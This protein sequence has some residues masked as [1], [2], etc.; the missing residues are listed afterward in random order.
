M[1]YSSVRFLHIPVKNTAC[2]GSSRLTKGGLLSL[3]G[4]SPFV[5]PP[6]TGPSLSEE[7]KQKILDV[8]DE[9]GGNLNRS[10][11]ILGI[12][13]SSLRRRIAEWASRDAAGTP[14]ESVSSTRRFY[15]KISHPWSVTSFNPE[16]REV[17]IEIRT[18][19]SSNHL[20]FTVPS[21]KMPE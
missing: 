11:V 8:I 1:R 16:K 15:E 12:S 2:S 9:N 10:S 19:S 13:A 6:M 4:Y 20:A 3:M 5:S 7:K 21:T 18:P 14:S 17:C